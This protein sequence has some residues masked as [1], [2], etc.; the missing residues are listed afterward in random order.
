[1]LL[2]GAYLDSGR[3]GSD[4]SSAGHEI[5]D[6]HD[7]GENQKDM[8]PSAQCVATDKPHDPEDE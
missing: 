7:D 5:E 3:P 6:E 4:D 1:V 2:R 8:N